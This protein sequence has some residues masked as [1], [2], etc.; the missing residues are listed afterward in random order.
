MRDERG[1]IYVEALIAVAVLALGLIPIFGGWSVTA[2]AQHQT[3]RKNEALSIARANIEPL[4]M[5]GGTAWDSLPASQSI[6]NPADP[7]YTIVRSVAPRA[8]Q[9]GLKDV[10]VTVTWVDQ[11]GSTQSV[12]LT[13]AVARRP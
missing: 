4:H 5:L 8:D 13:T 10:T 7:G 9:T 11:K 6:P 2:G 12:A 1:N 3:G